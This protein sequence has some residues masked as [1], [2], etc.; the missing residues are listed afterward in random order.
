MPKSHAPSI[1]IEFLEVP[2]GERD[3]KII[4]TTCRWHVA[5]TSSK[6]GGYHNCRPFPGDNASKSL[7]LR[8][9]RATKKI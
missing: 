2:Y 5:A 7:S 6:T 9:Q 3:L 8:H 1:K 4:I